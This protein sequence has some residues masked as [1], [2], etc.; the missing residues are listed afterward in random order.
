MMGAGNSGR[1]T[2]VRAQEVTEMAATFERHAR[3]LDDE[4]SERIAR[5]VAAHHRR[6]EKLHYAETGSMGPIDEDWETT[7]EVCRLIKM[8]QP[9]LDGD[10]EGAITRLLHALEDEEA[11]ASH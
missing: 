5:H 11:R 9:E 1:E 7:C 3:T 2:A 8:A 4:L 10:E 6:A